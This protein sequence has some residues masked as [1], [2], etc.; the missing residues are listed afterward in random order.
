MQGLGRWSTT[1]QFTKRLL[2]IPSTRRGAVAAVFRDKDIAVYV[3][4]DWQVRPNLTVNTG[5]RWENFTPLSNK[6][7]EINYPFW[8][9]GSD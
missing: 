9:P 1:R 6:G 8:A 4:H 3:Q 2:P 7:F 5:L